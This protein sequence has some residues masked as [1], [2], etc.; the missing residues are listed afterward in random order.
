MLS[1]GVVFSYVLLMFGTQNFMIMITCS[2]DVVFG[3][4]LH[5][6]SEGNFINMYACSKGHGLWLHF[7]CV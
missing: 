5:M 1:G 4:I 3:Y 6:F 2:R 7:T